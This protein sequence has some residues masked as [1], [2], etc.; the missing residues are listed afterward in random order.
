MHRDLGSVPC[1]RG[2]GPRF[3]YGLATPMV[4]SP[5][6]ISMC[7]LFLPSLWRL[8][9][10]TWFVDRYSFDSQLEVY[11]CKYHLE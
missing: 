7:N 2:E 6:V 8:M 3:D 9:K 1:F 4:E 11:T 10:A 5:A